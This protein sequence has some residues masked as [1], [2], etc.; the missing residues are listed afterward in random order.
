MRAAVLFEVK[1]PL[2]LNAGPANRR[3]RSHRIRR[4]PSPPE[5]SLGRGRL[6]VSEGT[7]LVIVGPDPLRESCGWSHGRRATDAPLTICRLLVVYTRSS[8]SRLPVGS[9]MGGDVAA[10]RL[11]EN[12]ER[13]AGIRTPVVPRLVLG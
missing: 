1:M 13:Q 2:D 8:R 12:R 3:R 5:T 9:P 4:S 10:E 7:A 6:G 11:K